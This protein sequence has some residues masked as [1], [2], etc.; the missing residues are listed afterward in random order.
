[1]SGNECGLPILFRNHTEKR[2]ESPLLQQH[3]VELMRKQGPNGNTRKYCVPAMQGGIA[4][5]AAI[6]RVRIFRALAATR[7]PK[8][9]PLAAFIKSVCVSANRPLCLHDSAVHSITQSKICVVCIGS[10]GHGIPAAIRSA[11]DPIRG[12]GILSTLWRKLRTR[13]TSTQSHL[14]KAT[15][16]RRQTNPQ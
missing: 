1:M 2:K 8:P 14:F 11:I 6:G 13:H 15:A 7:V 5:Y 12:A 16:K 4:K 10:C 9:L 3:R